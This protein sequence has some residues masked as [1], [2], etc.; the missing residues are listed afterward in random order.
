[1][2]LIIPNTPKY[3]DAEL[4]RAFVAEIKNSLELEKAT[5]IGRAHV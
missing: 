3:S 5:E 2:N 4:D 1:M